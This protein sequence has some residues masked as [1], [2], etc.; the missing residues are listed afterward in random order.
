MTIGVTA[1]ANTTSVLLTSHILV[2]IMIKINYRASMRKCVTLDMRD[3]RAMESDG[4]R[5]YRLKKRSGGVIFTLRVA[6][7]RVE[8]NEELAL[9]SFS[10]YTRFL[11]GP[12]VHRAFPDYH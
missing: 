7:P 6:A 8:P 3:W 11:G 12:R 1:R 5:H 4:L 2:Q 10:P 9:V